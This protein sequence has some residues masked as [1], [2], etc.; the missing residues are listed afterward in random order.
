MVPSRICFFLKDHIPPVILSA[1]KDQPPVL[2]SPYQCNPV[3]LAA[4][5]PNVVDS[6]LPT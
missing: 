4:V 2:G 6:R 1:A 3:S 5:I